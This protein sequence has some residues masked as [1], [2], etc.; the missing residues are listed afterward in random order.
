VE[1]PAL[2]LIPVP[3]GDT[4]RFPAVSGQTPEGSVLLT[5]RHFIVENTRSARRFLKR[6]YPDIV[7]DALTFF[8]LDKHAPKG[9]V[10]PAFLQ[11]LADG[12]SIGLLSEA[13]CPAVAD[14]GAD[15]V[16]EAHRRGFTVI[17]L[18]GPSSILLAL[19][20][21]GFNGQS[22]A[23]N[24]YLPVERHERLRAIRRVENDAITR[25]QTQ[26]FIETPYRNDALAAD[27][28]RFCRP[29]I[30]LCLATSLT[31]PD[32]SIRTRTIAQWRQLGLPTLASRPT[33]FL[34]SSP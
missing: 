15:I 3:L 6:V 10:S 23:F 24:G 1:P 8:E 26:I 4:A 7:I 11:P 34:L 33:I 27:I 12:Y 14:P 13:G 16:A 21:S 30:L 9:Q 18:I 25:R 17:P 19:M 29:D 2:Y 22:F 20:A 32:E 5:L 28:L 31:C